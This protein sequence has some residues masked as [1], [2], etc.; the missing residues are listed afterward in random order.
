MQSGV[1]KKQS[2]CFKSKYFVSR[3]AEN[4]YFSEGVGEFHL[5][6]QIKN[7]SAQ[8]FCDSSRIKRHLLSHSGKKP[9]LC[10]LCG[11]GF[12]QKCNMDRH[13]ASHAKVRLRG[14]SIY[15]YFILFLSQDGVTNRIR[16]H[17]YLCVYIGDRSATTGVSSIFHARWGKRREL[18]RTCHLQ[19][20]PA[21]YYTLGNMLP[22]LG[23]GQ[24]ANVAWRGGGGVKGCRDEANGSSIRVKLMQMELKCRQK[25]VL[26]G[27]FHQIFYFFLT[28]MKLN[29]YSTF[30][31]AANGFKCLII[32]YCILQGNFLKVF[33]FNSG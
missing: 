1:N 31:R 28:S 33:I 24:S 20:V 11:W 5:Q 23:G 32:S 12:Y 30:W 3:P 10:P 18:D 4:I 25:R 16:I 29:K 8:V 19:A 2:D 6:T 9:F 14:C 26:K 17:T 22:T 15:F 27:Q 7:L 21:Y 13:L